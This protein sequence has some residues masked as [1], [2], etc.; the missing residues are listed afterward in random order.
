MNISQIVKTEFAELQGLF[1]S[2]V[3]DC[4]MLI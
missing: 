4:G 3:A 2:I 1:Y